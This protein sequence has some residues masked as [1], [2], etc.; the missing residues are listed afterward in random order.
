MLDASVA[1]HHE[2]SFYVEEDGAV[3]VSGLCAG[4]PAHRLL[5]DPRLYLALAAGMLA[6]AIDGAAAMVSLMAAGTFLISMS[7]RPRLADRHEAY[8]AFTPIELGVL[9]WTA[10][11]RAIMA[12]GARRLATVSAGFVALAAAS[13]IAAGLVFG[14]AHVMLAAA[15]CLL[16]L[17]AL[18]YAL[19]EIVRA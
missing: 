10:E 13:V 17:A 1:K 9:L 5:I 16:C 7:V 18:R 3:A 12:A 2:R 8:G 11:P 15:I 19:T 6:V 14:P 4:V